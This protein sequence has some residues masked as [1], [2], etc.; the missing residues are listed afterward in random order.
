M[1]RA[2]WSGAISFGL[3]NVPVRL[4]SAVSSKD[5]R[6]NMIHGEDGGRI[7][8]RRVCSLDGE[9]VPFDEILKG[10]ELSTGQFVVIEPKELQQLDPKASRTI[11]IEDFVALEH[12]DPVYFERTYYTAPD[13]GASKAYS[14]LLR[15]MRDTK[16]VAIARMVMRSKGY[17]CCLRP[18]GEGLAVS[19]MY[20]ADEVQS[21]EGIA[22]LDALGEVDA[23]ERELEM[24]VSLVDSLSSEFEPGRYSD[25]YREKVLELVERKAAGKK[26]VSPPE[27][28]A[29]EPMN[30]AD[31]L[32][33]S[34]EEARRRK[35]QQDE[36]ELR[37]PPNG[38]VAARQ[39]RQATKSSKGEKGLVNSKDDNGRKHQARSKKSSAQK[40][41]KSSSPSR[42]RK[43]EKGSG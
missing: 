17:L 7:R 29:P 34:L 42:G 10:Y 1:A 5:L 21:Q 27:A 31:A 32:A 30:L 18:L 36:G 9:E 40:T 23:S 33:R 28:P 2:I 13:K 3:V 24:A 14:L 20:Y 39:K 11:E 37:A 35:A 38:A 26:L 25:F 15:A 12:I 19:T 16:R 8:L 4:F 22:A 43:T 6:F 41:Q